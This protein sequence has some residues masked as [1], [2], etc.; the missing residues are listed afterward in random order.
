MNYYYWVIIKKS[1]V[2]NKLI[3]G[4]ILLNLTASI[5]ILSMVFSAFQ[6]G[7]NYLDDEAT[8]VTNKHIKQIQLN[9]SVSYSSL[10][11]L[12]EKWMQN[13][14]IISGASLLSINVPVVLNQET[15]TANIIG[16]SQEYFKIFNYDVA[17]NFE[18]GTVVITTDMA[19]KL[20]INKDIENYYLVIKGFDF[21]IYTSIDRRGE[22]VYLPVKNFKTLFPDDSVRVLYLESKDEQLNDSIIEDLKSFNPIVADINALNENSTNNFTML[23]RVGSIMVAMLFSFSMLGYF[24]LYSYKMIRD[25][26]RWNVFFIHGAKK[27]HLFKFILYEMLFFL[28]TSF[29]LAICLYYLLINTALFSDI[30]FTYGITVLIK[31]IIVISIVITIFQ[32]INFINIKKKIYPGY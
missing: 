20:K 1:L 31:T 17:S 2:R 26:E 4:L 11:D 6:Y 22:T 21:K 15:Y 18:E 3:N 10:E 13:Q 25:K 24:Y 14:L 23:S 7:L 27:T 30:G 9:N 12:I 19:K 16:T 28:L 32:F 8:K 29:F 5:L